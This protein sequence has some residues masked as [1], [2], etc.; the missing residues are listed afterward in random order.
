MP[1]KYATPNIVV[2]RIT[3]KR[4]AAILAELEERDKVAAK[5]AW[6]GLSVEQ[7]QMLDQR[8][9]GES[10]HR[11]ATWWGSGDNAMRDWERAALAE[12]LE[13]FRAY[14]QRGLVWSW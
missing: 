14:S 3:S 9:R 11:L 4:I 2:G 13:A 8:A 12:V 6:W 1:T 5:K 7:R 10:R